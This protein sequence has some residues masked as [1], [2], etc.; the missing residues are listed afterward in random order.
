MKNMSRLGKIWDGKE[1]EEVLNEF[2]EDLKNKGTDVEAVIVI[3]SRA[4]GVWKPSSDIDVVI[5]VKNQEDVEKVLM[6]KRI[7]LIDPKI[8]TVEEAWEALKK[9]DTTIVEALEYGI[10]IYDKGIWN[11]IKKKYEKTLKNKIKIVLNKNKQIIQIALL[12]SQN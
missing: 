4:R 10:E 7:G 6:A 3:G 5:I 12:E 9:V 8:Y 11:L 1:A 2:L